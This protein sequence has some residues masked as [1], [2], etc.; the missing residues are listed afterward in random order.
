MRG[1]RVLGPALAAVVVLSV[2]TAVVVLGGR[3]APAGAVTAT[4]GQVITVRTGS[5][6]ATS[7]VLEAWQ[8]QVN[9]SYRRV[10]GPVPAWVG[11]AGVGAT[12]EGLS[13]TPAG[14]FRLSESFGIAADPGTGLP[15]R[16][17]DTNDWWVSDV[18]SALYNTYQRCAP[19]TC[20]FNQNAS[21]RLATIPVYKYATVIDYNRRPVV[22]G[23]GSAFFLHVANGRP[24][25]GCV[26]VAEAH[27]VWLMRWLRAASTPYVSIGVGSAATAPVANANAEAARHNPLGRFERLTA[28]APGR[29]RVSGWARDPDRPTWSIRVHVYADNRPVAS[30]GTAATTNRYDATL[31]VARGRHTVC[32]YAINIGVGTVNPRLGCATVTVP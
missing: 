13:R 20:P 11:S 10:Y 15:Y 25:A 32:V 12:R 27:L 19:G 2:A 1:R 30:I 8:K 17:V 16:R 18:G 29:I 21:E 6:A 5:A 24:T 9:G 26:A 31:A 28:P 4:T 3:P 23:A 14:F 22:R 7:G